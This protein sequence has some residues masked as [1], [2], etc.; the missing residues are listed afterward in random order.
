MEVTKNAGYIYFS[1]CCL[2]Q[3]GLIALGWGLHQRLL[4]R[5]WSGMLPN[6]REFAEK[7]KE[8]NG[9]RIL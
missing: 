3:I 5:G 1:L 8:S 4:K 6:V 2:W 9:K 7:V